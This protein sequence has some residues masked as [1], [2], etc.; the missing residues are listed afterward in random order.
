MSILSNTLVGFTI[1][2]SRF[3]T[4]HIYTRRVRESAGWEWLSW[5]NL[6]TLCLRMPAMWHYP[7]ATTLESTEASGSSVLTS[8]SAVLLGTRRTKVS[9]SLSLVHF[10]GTYGR[11][12]YRPGEILEITG[13]W[14]CHL[15]YR[16]SLCS[17]KTIALWVLRHQLQLANCWL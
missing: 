17:N 12:Q 10:L 13:S 8:S 1:L 9:L 16:Y 14:G 15:P 6:K 4:F 5:D 2:M 3:E 11:P 7:K